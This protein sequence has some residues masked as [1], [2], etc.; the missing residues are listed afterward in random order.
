[1]RYTSAPTSDTSGEI[2]PLSGSGALLSACLSRIRGD[3]GAAVGRA[4][5]VIRFSPR[6]T[7]NLNSLEFAK[8]HLRRLGDVG[9]H[10]AR[11]E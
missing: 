11:T 1:M 4:E 2:V 7:L 3:V 9:E 6:T 8:C 10:G 5:I